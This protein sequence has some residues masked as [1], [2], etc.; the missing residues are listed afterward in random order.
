MLMLYTDS[1]APVDTVKILASR[2]HSRHRAGRRRP[3]APSLLRLLFVACEA[4]SAVTTLEIRGL[5]GKA[6]NASGIYTLSDEKRE[7][8]ARY[9]QEDGD[10]R[11]HELSHDGVGERTHSLHCHTRHCMQ[12]MAPNARGYGR[13]RTACGVRH[14]VRFGVG[15]AACLT[16]N[17]NG[18]RERGP[19]H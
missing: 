5:T 15:K 4:M 8:Y 7:G 12:L 16:R 19:W 14:S 11:G 17:G 10:A 1:Q 3:S 2:R 13:S 6:Q 9:T 18:C